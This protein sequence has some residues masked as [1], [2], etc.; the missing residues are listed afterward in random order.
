MSSDNET[1]NNAVHASVPE[2]PPRASP[3]HVAVEPPADPAQLTLPLPELPLPS[4]VW[5]VPRENRVFVNRNLRLSDIQWIGFD[6]DYTLAIY[7][8]AEM[9]RIQIEATLAGLVKRGYP[10]Y[11]RE[12]PYDTAFPIRGL[13]IDKKYGNVLK[14]DRYKVVHKAWHGMKALGQEALDEL[15]HQRKVRLTASRYHWV[16]TLYALAEVTIYA[17]LL[18]ALE[19][20]GETVDYEKLFADIRESIDAAHRDGTILELVAADLPRFV[21]RDPDLAHT[22]HRWRSAGKRLF[23]LTNSRFS[24][25]QAMMTYLLAGAMPE[26][27]SWRHYFDAIVVAAGKPAF[28]EEQRPLM[29]RDGDTLRPASPLLERGKVYESGNL[30]ELEKL[31]GVTGDRIL[32][33]GDHIYGDILRSKKQ[34]SWRTAMIIQEMANEI[35][36]YHECQGALAQL[37]ELAAQ[38]QEA[39]DELRYLQL[40]FKQ[41]SR[42]IE[43]FAAQGRG[44]VPSQVLEAE[45]TRV[46]RRLE[47]VRGAMRQLE[48]QS[49]AI[50]QRVDQRFHAYWGS[51]LKE[52]N[53]TSSFGDQVEEYACLYTSK[54]SNF[55][56]YSPLQHYRSPRD[57]M[58]HEL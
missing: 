21:M 16:D 18:E 8:Q 55:L 42:Q 48:A 20:R 56:A 44:L 30:A 50:E 22:L 46:K 11:V 12:I 58:P 17:S 57:R 52:G 23:L 35:S 2:L 25:T 49:V 3:L 5:T 38:R 10:A 47:S 9:D 4:Q 24:Y 14:M 26:Y 41:L 54:V 32:Y 1:N 13:V 39:E 19:Q 43:T 15:Y 45:R 28:F 40:K 27:P 36:A 31:L 53:E 37:E 29:E 33:V 34:S 6:M 7:H 51:L